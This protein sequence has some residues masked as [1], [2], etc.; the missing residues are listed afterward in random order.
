MG[1]MLGTSYGPV[2][3]KVSMDAGATWSRCRGENLEWEVKRKTALTINKLQDFRIPTS[4]SSHCAEILNWLDLWHQLIIKSL[5]CHRHH[6]PELNTHSQFGVQLWKACTEGWYLSPMNLW[7]NMESTPYKNIVLW[8]FMIGLNTVQEHRETI[9][10]EIGIVNDRRPLYLRVRA[11]GKLP[12]KNTSFS[13]AAE[14]I[15]TGLVLKYIAV[16]AW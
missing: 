11:V 1:G 12:I 6:M 16:D 5:C 4:P 13:R 10:Y 15:E 9:T 3:P 7:N 14:T 8:C 2:L